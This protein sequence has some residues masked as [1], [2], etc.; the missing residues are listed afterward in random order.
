LA[1]G[2]ITDAQPAARLPANVVHQLFEHEAYPKGDFTG[3]VWPVATATRYLSVHNWPHG[4]F[5]I[6]RDEN[7]RV[8]LWQLTGEPRRP[9]EVPT[10]FG[11][12]PSPPQ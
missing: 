4:E 3:C 10:I 6:M 2:E 12:L 8:H 11:A 1:P 7:D 9:D 5:Y